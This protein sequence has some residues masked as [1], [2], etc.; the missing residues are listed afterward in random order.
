MKKKNKMVTYRIPVNS[1]QNKILKNNLFYLIYDLLRIIKKVTYNIQ[2]VIE[3]QCHP[4][5]Q[6]NLLRK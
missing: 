4:V 1:R 2:L 3:L 6:T 5:Q